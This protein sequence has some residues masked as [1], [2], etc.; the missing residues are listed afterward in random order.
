MIASSALLISA[1]ALF[2]TINPTA[3]SVGKIGEL[4]LEPSEEVTAIATI[5]NLATGEI[6]SVNSEP[7][8]THSSS[9]TNANELPEETVVASCNVYFPI[10]N[11]ESTI[12]PL[13]T[14]SGSRH[15]GGVT[16]TINVVYQFN[17]KQDEIKTIRCYGGWTPDNGLYY[18]T[19][20]NVVVI[21][22]A[23]SGYSLNKYPTTNSFD[24]YTG[25]GYI[26]RQP[27]GTYQ[28]QANS[29]ATV[30]V[31]G[32]ESAGGYELSLHVYYGSYT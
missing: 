23:L 27:D 31:G 13:D 11:T 9:I 24:Y 22:G 28:Q 12:Q 29:Y 5:K 3:F 30:Y 2:C 20:R 8:V 32:M 1:L 6:I 14:E 7:I 10:E 18:L 15:A 17:T 26:I 19:A 4:E 25:W 16:A 21:P